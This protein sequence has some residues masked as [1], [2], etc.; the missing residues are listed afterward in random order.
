MPE[1]I[2]ATKAGLSYGE[3]APMP[4]EAPASWRGRLSGHLFWNKRRFAVAGDV[5]LTL[6]DAGGVARLSGRIDNFVLAP[7]DLE[8]LQP[9]SGPPLPWRSL[10]LHAALAQEGAW[11]GVAVAD[12]QDPTGAPADMPGADAFRGDWRAAA[13]GPAAG[14]VAGRL[15]LWT[16]LAVGA[17]PTTDWPGQALLVAGFGAVRTQ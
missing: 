1:R 11:S 15:R 13:H 9:K 5:V 16:P 17:D 12:A 4:P 2:V 7:L 14:E 10:L 8:T 3:A 6:E